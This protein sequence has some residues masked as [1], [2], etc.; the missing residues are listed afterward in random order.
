MQ[1]PLWIEKQLR[2]REQ[3][4]RGYGT[5][6]SEEHSLSRKRWCGCLGRCLLKSPWISV[7]IPLTSS[8]FRP[9]Q[10]ILLH[11]L[12]QRYIIRAEA[13]YPHHE[14][15]VFIRMHHGIPEHL[16]GDGVDLHFLPAHLEIGADQGGQAGSFLGIAE[17]RRAVFF[18]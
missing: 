3:G 17:H 18:D 7:M 1:A 15:A 2:G 4:F 14:I 8:M 10:D 11:R 9:H 12:V 5:R 16:P 13:G 6:G